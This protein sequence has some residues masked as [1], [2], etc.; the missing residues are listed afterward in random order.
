MP[1]FLFL[2]I[3]HLYFS[4]TVLHCWPKM[5]TVCVSGHNSNLC[6]YDAV[7]FFGSRVSF[8]STRVSFCAPRRSR[9]VSMVVKRSP[10]RL[11]YTSG[12]RFTKVCFKL[13][14]CHAPVNFDCSLLILTVNDWWCWIGGWF[15]V[16]WSR[17]FCLWCLEIG[18]NCEFVETR[19]CWSHTY[20]YHVSAL[21]FSCHNFEIVWFFLFL[22]VSSWGA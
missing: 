3:S 1:T 7:S 18:T 11:K 4:C 6:R 17:P 2:Q 19:C 16:H 20:W 5:Q 21:K 22:Y 10:K 13:A 8:P 12:S 14:T 15:G 9:V